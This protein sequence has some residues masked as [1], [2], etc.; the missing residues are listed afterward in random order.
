M[1][2]EELIKLDNEIITL[3]K[4]L[5]QRVILLSFFV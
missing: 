4:D 3:L 2:N 1:K 5:K